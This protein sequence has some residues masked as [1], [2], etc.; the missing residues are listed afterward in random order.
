MWPPSLN[1]LETQAYPRRGYDSAEGVGAG[2][3]PT[4]R[5][6]TVRYRRTMTNWMHAGW[7]VE[8]GALT[9]DLLANNAI[10]LPET[11]SDRDKMPA[12]YR[13][14]REQPLLCISATDWN[15][16]TSIGVPAYRIAFNV[17]DKAMLH[18]DRKGERSESSLVLPLEPL[19]QRCVRAFFRL[20]AA[21]SHPWTCLFFGSDGIAF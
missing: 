21:S 20:N 5:G 12:A 13:W 10:L 8:R 11:L 2:T 14:L 7:V 17:S 9:P 6:L 18:V 19:Y 4:V 15:R 16:L 1:L 3:P